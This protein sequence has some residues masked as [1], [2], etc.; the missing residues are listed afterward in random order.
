MWWIVIVII[1]VLLLFVSAFIF[2]RY[3]AKDLG[4][5]SPCFK[6]A[7]CS[8]GLT[9]VGGFCTAINNGGGKIG[10]GGKCEESNQCMTGLICKD[11]VCTKDGNNGT[12]IPV[13]ATCTKTGLCVSGAY[14]S[15]DMICQSGTAPPINSKCTSNNQCLLGDFCSGLGTCQTDGNVPN[16]SS[17]RLSSQCITGSYCV[18]ADICQSGNGLVTSFETKIVTTTITNQSV[19]NQILYLDTRIF[20]TNEPRDV[21]YIRQYDEITEPRRFFSY[22][23]TTFKLSYVLVDK[24]YIKINSDGSLTG[25]SNEDQ[26][27]VIYIEGSTP[28]Q[29]NI[30]SD[31]FFMRD[32][33]GN[34][35]GFQDNANAQIVYFISDTHYSN[36]PEGLQADSKLKFV[37]NLN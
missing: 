2:I 20:F 35:L 13:G 27:S 24:F 31:D 7:Q 26:A 30:A 9:C 3:D 32:E 1:I 22:D 36:Q 11:N 4:E 21:I 6:T 33:F 18:F 12:G 23:A 25:V 19:L 10:Q 15:A 8:T 16:G 37:S 14:C 17:C 5:G 29:H 28:S 34:Y